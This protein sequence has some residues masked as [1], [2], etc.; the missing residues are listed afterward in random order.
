MH[1]PRS[2]P[3]PP[4]RVTVP[5]LIR[6][7]FVLMILVVAGATALPQRGGAPSKRAGAPDD[8]DGTEGN[9]GTCADVGC[10]NSFALNAGGGSISV[11]PPAF[12]APGD[13]ILLKVTVDHASASVFGFQITARDASGAPT[14]EW[15]PDSETRTTIGNSYYLTHVQATP[16]HEWNVRWVG[17]SAEAGDVVFYAAGNGSNGNFNAAGDY[18]YTTQAPVALSTTADV[19]EPG[20][21]PRP[22]VRIDDVYPN[23]ASDVITI[24][25]TSDHTVDV[26][27]YDMA[28][29][30]RAAES[31]RAPVSN[32]A[33][34]AFAIDGFPAGIY[35]ARVR[36]GTRSD[37]QL[38][39][40]GR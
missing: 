25:Y 15:I 10:H 18:V 34:V 32:G 16:T 20:A 39:F 8:G 4:Q 13:T 7:A 36:S 28:G 29:R 19:E 6:T 11:D 35:V 30:L 12:Y 9:S 24:R 22:V 33:D 17:P 3:S 38:F 37:S 2:F 1:A 26:E 31:T 5:A 21:K 40:V 23:P 27:I 14:G